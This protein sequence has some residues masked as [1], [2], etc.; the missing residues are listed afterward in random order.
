MFISKKVIF[1]LLAVILTFTDYAQKVDLSTARLAAQKFSLTHFLSKNKGESSSVIFQSCS[2]NDNDT[3]FF[4]FNIDKAGFIIVS[5]DSSVFPVLA[6]SDEGA[7]NDSLSS[8]ELNYWLNRL[9]RQISAA[10]NQKQPIPDQ[11]WNTCLNKKQTKGATKSATP[12]LTTKWDQVTDY[13]FYCPPSSNG[14]GGKCYTGC[15]ATAMAQIMYFYQYPQHG[16]GSNSYYHPH[17]GTISSDFSKVNFDWAS[18][19]TTISSQSD[20]QSIKSVACLIYNCGVAV[21]MDYSPS[22]SG[23]DVANAVTAF[24][25]YFNYSL[26]LKLVNRSDYN[27][28]IDWNNLLMSYIDRGIPILYEGIDPSVSGG[29]AFICD[30]YQD[31]CFF[32][33]NWGWSGHYNGYYYISNLDP[34]QYNLSTSEGAILDIVPYDYPYCSKLVNIT[35]STGTFDDGSGYSYYWNN[36]DCEWLITSPDTNKINLVFTDF[37]TEENH[38]F[39]SIYDGSDTNATILGRFSGHTLPP[40]IQS[41]GN[42]LLLHFVTNDSIQDEGWTVN[43]SSVPTG[44]TQYAVPGALMIY[45][46]P[47]NDFLNI[48]LPQNMKSDATLKIYN[49][50]GNL[51]R[52][53]IINLSDQSAINMP[54]HELSSGLYYLIINSNNQTICKKFIKQ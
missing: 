9:S 39:L 28:D 1:I 30:G 41:S 7:F 35:D 21:D 50:L 14:P 33:F 44:I 17:Y 31:S 20:S 54:V 13:N 25:Q 22:E 36:T 3:L 53:K 23:A 10:K 6:F 12:L 51:I 38:D 48:I 37:L 16:Y 29:H 46:D 40:V 5:G 19:T 2:T 52:V 18:M 49:T 8:P 15:V 47:A 27:S 45:P 4:I 43:Y 42:N 34:G 32:H 11:G 26:R 24:S